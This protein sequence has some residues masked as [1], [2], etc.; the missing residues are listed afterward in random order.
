MAFDLRSL[1]ITG[2]LGADPETKNTP[3]GATVTR[4]RVAVK[5][6]KEHTSWFTVSCWGKTGEIVQEYCFKGSKIAVTGDFST[7]EFDGN[8]GG[9]RISL[10]LNAQSVILLGSK[11]DGNGNG[12]N[13]NGGAAKPKPKA[14]QAESWDDDDQDIP[15]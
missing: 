3:N 5:D 14:A 1:S 11:S 7:R 4:L 6:G 13:G 9:K 8:D 2:N 12:G 10:D 15:F